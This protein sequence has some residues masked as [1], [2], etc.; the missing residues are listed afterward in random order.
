MY[1][2]M[3]VC[4]YVCMY[5]YVIHILIHPPLLTFFRV[6]LYSHCVALYSHL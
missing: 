1:V 4:V 3:Y 2:C 6:L 5:V